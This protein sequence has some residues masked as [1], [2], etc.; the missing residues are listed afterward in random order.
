MFELELLGWGVFAIVFF[1]LG[2]FADR[3]L[4]AYSSRLRNRSLGKGELRST[5][6]NPINEAFKNARD[7]LEE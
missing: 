3:G 2:I 6:H 7:G 4:M 1:A 5:G